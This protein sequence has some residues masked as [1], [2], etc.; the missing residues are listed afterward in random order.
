MCGD[1]LLVRVIEGRLTQ[2]SHDLS[3]VELVERQP[4]LLYGGKR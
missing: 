4:M 1:M 3:L 2:S